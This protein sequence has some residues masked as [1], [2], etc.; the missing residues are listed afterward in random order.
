MVFGLHFNKVSTVSFIS[1]KKKE[2]IFM[3]VISD[4]IIQFFDKFF[5]GSFGNLY[6]FK[7]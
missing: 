5:K 7:R 6:I 4:L 1:K 3:D 2:Q